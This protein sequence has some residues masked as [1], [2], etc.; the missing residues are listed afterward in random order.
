MIFI[1]Y[2]K[3]LCA[4]VGFGLESANVVGYQ[5]NAVPNGYSMITPCFVN[6]DGTDYNIDNFL[7]NG[8]EDT[9]ATV[10]VVNEDGSWGANGVWFNAYEPDNLPAG[11]FTDTSGL[12]PANITL[13]PGQAVFFNT[14]ATGASAQSAGQVPDIITM[15]IPNGYSMIG[16]ASAVPVAIDDIKLIGVEDTMA[17]VQVVNPDGS[18]GANG[19]WF[20]EYEPDNLPSGWFTDTTGLTSANIT[21]AP[22]QAVFFNAK[23]TGAKAVIPSALK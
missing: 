15:D 19:V 2:I 6:V 18:W 4:T 16:N 10:Q 23:A 20:N 5:A 1:P 14:K 22:G 9:M 8:V 12:T 13:K 11:W 17:T 7:L 21:L 3:T